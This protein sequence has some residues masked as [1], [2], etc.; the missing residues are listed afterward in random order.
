MAGY[1][2]GGYGEGGYGGGVAVAPAST[3]PRSAPTG[4]ILGCGTPSVYLTRV[5]GGQ[6]LAKLDVTAV[7]WRRALD[8]ISDCRVHLSVSQRDVRCAQVLGDIDDTWAYELNVYR[9]ADEAWVGPLTEP[10][11]TFTDMTIQARDLVQW[12]ERR[13]LPYDRAFV[14]TDLATIAAQYMVDALAIDPSPNI[15]FSVNPCGVEGDRSVLGITYR[16]AADEIR[17]LARG[18]LDFTT[19]G[20]TVLFGGKEIGAPRLPILTES[21]FEIS[22]YRLAG[23]QSANHWF[24]FGATPTGVTTPLVGEAGGLPNTPIVQLTAQEPSILDIP[25]A[26][27][28][29]QSRFEL[30]RTAPKMIAG[31]FLETAP[32]HIN[33]LIPGSIAEIRQQVGFKRVEGEYRLLAVECTA[34]VS[35]RGVVETVSGVFEPIGSI[36]GSL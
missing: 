30:L 23:L 15:S 21:S 13:I 19:V 24:V 18:G 31:R 20:R 25:S 17:E 1:G 8:E 34:D 7:V 10:V 16:R 33:D 11:Y 4:K 27:A 5:G 22:S 35:D 12:F 2:E 14:D 36:E 26:T 3:A 9:D 29:A 28:A 6:R 32:I